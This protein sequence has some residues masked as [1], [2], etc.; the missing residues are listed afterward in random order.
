MAVKVRNRPRGGL[1]RRPTG[2]VVKGGRTFMH[3]WF[4]VAALLLIGVAGCSENEQAAANARID[5][6][7]TGERTCK[8]GEAPKLAVSLRNQGN[9]DI[10]LIGSLDASDCKWRYP[11]CY[12]EVIGPNGVPS[13]QPLARCG[14]M[15]TLRAKDFVKVR[16]GETFDPYQRIDNYG[17]FSPHQ[18]AAENF[19]QPGKYRI[20]FVYS[21]TSTDIGDW[22]GDGGPRVASNSEIVRMFRMVPKVEAQ[23]DEF[24]LTVVKQ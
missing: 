20:R 15:N 19:T 8:L 12:F 21:T 11:H 24:E 18:F 10:Y 1:L 7:I 3:I 4:T 16:P 17:F 14:N 5:C 2:D 13:T 23:S 22:A 9:V 6:V